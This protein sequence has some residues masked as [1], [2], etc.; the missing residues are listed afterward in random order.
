MTFQTAINVQQ[1]PAVA[2]DFA[3]ANPRNSMISRPGGFVAGTNGVT[4][5]LF[6]WQDTST[7]TILANTGTGAP[8]GFMHRE[9]NATNYTY[10]SNG[11][12]LIPANQGIGGMFDAGDFWC[13]NAGAGSVTVG[14]KAFANNTNGTISFANTGATVS[15]STETKWYARSAGATGELIIISTTSPT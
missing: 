10:L 12:M 6:V 9:M 5:G 4:V 15:G 13:K 11:T 1:A 2:G 8:N 7:G 3:S 14:Q